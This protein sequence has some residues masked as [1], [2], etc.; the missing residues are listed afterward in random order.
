MNIL[1]NGDVCPCH[2]LTSREFRCGNVREHS[3]LDLC[4]SH[5]LLQRLRSLD[6][7]ELSAA[8]SRLRE[9]KQAGTCMGNVYADT[10][11]SAAW[12]HRLPILGACDRPAD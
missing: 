8:D 3:L 12:S 11:D 2:V 6:F 1:P 10:R 4:A 9:L 7:R 5:G